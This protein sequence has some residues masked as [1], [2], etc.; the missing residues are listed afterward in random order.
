MHPASI[1]AVCHSVD[2]AFTCASSLLPL[3]GSN[4][5]SLPALLDSCRAKRGKWVKLTR[6]E[7]KDVERDRGGK[8]WERHRGEWGGLSCKDTEH[9]P[10]WHLTK[11]HCVPRFAIAV[12]F[13][14]AMDQQNQWPTWATTMSY[15]LECTHFCCTPV[16]IYSYLFFYIQQNP[17]LKNYIFVQL[18]TKI[19]MMV[20]VLYRSRKYNI[21]FCE[22]N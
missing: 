15:D 4:A 19:L 21:W 14:L 5:H 6:Q 18:S 16:A 20:T 3:V 8:V 1:T 9:K 7:C 22:S 13:G 12:G 10:W 2:A 11:K 17:D